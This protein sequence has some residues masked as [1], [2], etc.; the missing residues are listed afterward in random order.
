MSSSGSRYPSDNV[1]SD[2]GPKRPLTPPIGGQRQPREVSPSVLTIRSNARFA[3]GL[4]CAVLAGL[5][6]AAI[7]GCKQTEDVAKVEPPDI[8]MVS[9]GNE[10]R[11]ALSY[12]VAKGTNA[13]LEV[14]VDMTVNAGEM[15]G[16]LPT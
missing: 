7:A 1:G 9:A 6:V 8:Q 13:G 2:P 5:A 12:H 4:R 3:R 10:P 14:E 16:P 11:K 15:G